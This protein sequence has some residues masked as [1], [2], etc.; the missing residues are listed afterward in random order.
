ME[1]IELSDLLGAIEAYALSHYDI[2]LRDLVKMLQATKSAFEDGTRK[3]EQKWKCKRC[4]S[5]VDM[6]K[7]K[8][9][10]TKSPSPWELVE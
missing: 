1:L 10:C 8:C 2:E 5:I 6:K 7:F 4:N 9:N 3:I